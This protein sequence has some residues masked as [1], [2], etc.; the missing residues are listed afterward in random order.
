[1]L[2]L[3]RRESVDWVDTGHWL[4]E[5]LSAGEAGPASAET[6]LQ[7]TIEAQGWNAD[8]QA[9]V[10]RGF[11]DSLIAADPSVAD[12]LRA[13]LA[14]MAEAEREMFCG[15]CGNAMFITEVGISHHVG[16]SL[17]GIDHGRDRDHTAVAETEPDTQAD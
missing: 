3:G 13:H 16:S 6:I 17:H 5:K 4:D 10:L 8:S 9:F 1:M 7:P 2:D 11:I 15:S 12:C 14:A